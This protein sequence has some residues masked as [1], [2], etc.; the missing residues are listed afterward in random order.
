[1]FSALLLSLSFFVTD[2]FSLEIELQKESER[3][4]ESMGWITPEKLS[5]QEQMQVII[6]QDNL[7]NRISLFY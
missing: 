4:Q 2:V 1:M 3:I 7:K 5:Y 6:D